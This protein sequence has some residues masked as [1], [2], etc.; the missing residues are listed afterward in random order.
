MG[1][2]I[3]LGAE[4]MLRSTFKLEGEAKRKSVLLKVTADNQFD[5]EGVWLRGNLHCHVGGR[6]RIAE[7]RD[8]Y[9]DHGFDFLAATD[10]NVV[11][12]FPPDGDNEF[13]SITG[14]ELSDAHLVGIGIEHAPPKEPPSGEGIARLVKEVGSQGGI[15]ILAHPH[16]MGWRWDDLRMAGESGIAGFEV[17]N[18][19]CH[20]INGKGRSDQLWEMLLKEGFRPAAIGSDDSHNRDHPGTGKVWTGV[21][22]ADRSPESVLEAIQ[23]GRTYASEGPEIKSIKWEDPGVVVVECSPCVACH[24]CSEGGGARSMFSEFEPSEHFELD[25]ATQGYRIRNRLRID[26]AD[27]RGRHAWS[28]AMDVSVSLEER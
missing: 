5:L 19:L 8:W 27:G 12:P 21:L 16:W 25:L 3:E 28:S 18:A 15:A 6:D 20:Y 11:T 7:T 1:K 13:V 4:T 26:L 2:N 22:A 14:S 9:R 17:S 10:H 23:A 24:F